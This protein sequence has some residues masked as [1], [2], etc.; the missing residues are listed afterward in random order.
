MS[1]ALLAT[2]RRR[3]IEKRRQRTP[4]CAFMAEHGLDQ[5]AQFVLHLHRPPPAARQPVA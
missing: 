5:L 1:P 2:S 3:Q 4:A